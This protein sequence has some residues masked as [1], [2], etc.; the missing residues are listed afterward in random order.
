[1]RS[2]PPRAP[3]LQRLPRARPARPLN[4]GHPARNPGHAA[5]LPQRRPACPNHTMTPQPLP[6]SG[7]WSGPDGNLSDDHRCIEVAV[8]RGDIEHKVNRSHMCKHKTFKA[9]CVPQYQPLPDA[10]W[11]SKTERLRRMWTERDTTSCDIRIKKG[12]DE[13]V[14]RVGAGR[15]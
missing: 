1:D 3:G 14:H 13:C 9:S 8:R 15:E 11:I 10:A 12:C 7:T 4:P 6:A 2:P 5:R